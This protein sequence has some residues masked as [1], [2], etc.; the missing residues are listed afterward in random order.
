MTELRRD[1][2]RE[3]WVLIA[4]GKALK[5]SDFLISK[6]YNNISTI[7]NPGVCPFC[8]GNE[9]HT[10]G[11]L[12]ACRINGSG[13]DEPGW[14]IRTVP[15]KYSMFNMRPGELAHC[16]DGIYSR[17]NGL[18]QHEVVIETPVHNL[19]LHELPEEQTINLIYMLQQR[20]KALAADP[21]IKYIQIYKNRGLLA[22]ASQEHS[23]SQILAFPMVPDK[24]RGITSYYY[25]QGKCLICRIIADEI[26]QRERI[27]YES[28]HFVILCPYAPRFSYETWIIPKKH[29][30]FFADIYGD[31]IKE[32]QAVIRGYLASMLA[33]LEDPSYNIMINSAPVNTPDID[34][35]HW[36]IEVTP[37]LVITN[38]VEIASGYFINPVAPEAAAQV[39]RDDL[40][41]KF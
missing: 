7:V 14:L 13:P 37:R 9:A 26:E 39:L 8:E 1:I 17:C 40:L 6:S 3:S 27:I 15:N 30:S 38:A 21:R 11:E 16:T 4:G 19:Q 18:G 22:G 5:P 36:Y 28:D 20:F 12:A 35:Y 24:N 34:A 32:L 31:E 23:H 10:P 2:V 29:Q 33:C 25:E 41:I